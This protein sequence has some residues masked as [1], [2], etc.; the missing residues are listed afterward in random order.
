MLPVPSEG[1]CP[2][3]SAGTS[4]GVSTQRDEDTALALYEALRTKDGIPREDLYSAADLD[5][6]HVVRG[7]RRLHELGL[8]QVRDGVAEAVDPDAALARAM[9]GYQANAAEQL[10]SGVRLQRVTEALLTVY[11]PAVQRETS[12]VAVEFITGSRRK[13]RTRLDLTD[14]ARESCGSMHPGPMPAIEVLEASLEH[15]RTIMARGIRSRA[16]YPISCLHSP[17][18]ARYLHDLADAGV[19]VRLV[20][21]AP[22]DMLTFDRDAAVLAADPERP[23]EAVIVIRGAALMRSYLAVYEDCWLRGQTL[24]RASATNA[25]DTEITTQE[26]VIIRL[27]ASGLSD[28]QIARKLGV[29]RRTVQRAVAKLMERL[30]ATSRFEAG[31]KLAND[32]EF[33]TTFAVQ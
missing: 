12:E 27:M 26:R 2:T 15:D 32:A 7:W 22:F 30:N 33:A 8:I 19:E 5:D 14:A 17:K 23:S 29:H 11:R 9:D 6:A 31:L 13:Q 25:E 16:I 4:G 10:R 20:D 18:Y 28:D 24:A 21:H 3:G 1:A